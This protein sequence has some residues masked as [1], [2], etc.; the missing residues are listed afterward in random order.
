MTEVTNYDW[1]DGEMTPVSESLEDMLIAEQECE[2]SY[3]S[4]LAE[5]YAN[6]TPTE[7]HEEDNDEYAAIN[8]LF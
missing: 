5:A 2:E 4:E 8:H 3:W 1:A 7:V 6:H